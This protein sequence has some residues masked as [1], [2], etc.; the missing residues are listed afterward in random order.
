MIHV[1]PFAFFVGSQVPPRALC[2]VLIR[3]EGGSGHT[4][5]TSILGNLVEVKKESRAMTKTVTDQRGN[6]H[7][8]MEQRERY[9]LVS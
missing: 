1:A 9:T 6:N 2:P 8:K 4:I 3:P 5:S 7:P